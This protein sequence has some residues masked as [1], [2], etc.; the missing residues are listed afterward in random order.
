M[1]D[2]LVLLVDHSCGL[3]LLPLT[4]RVTYILVLNTFFLDLTF[5]KMRVVARDTLCFRVQDLVLVLLMRPWESTLLVLSILFFDIVM[6]SGVLLLLDVLTRYLSR[7]MSVM[8]SVSMIEGIRE[9][10]QCRGRWS[11]LR[12]THLLDHHISFY[13]FC[14][15]VHLVK[16]L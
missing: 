10:L 1:F 9:L 16:V 12:T 5:G 6:K 2:Y 15:L 7:F 14:R 13:V 11:A 4:L 8:I 3:F